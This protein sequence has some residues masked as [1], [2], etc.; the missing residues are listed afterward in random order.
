M[1]KKIF[2]PVSLGS[3]TAKN[4]LVRSGTSQ[5]MSTDLTYSNEKL[6]EIY[7][8]LADGGVGTNI[9]SFPLVDSRVYVTNERSAFEVYGKITDM[10]R[11]KNCISIAQLVLVNA[12]GND[13]NSVCDMFIRSAHTA[14]ECGYDGIQ[15]HAAHGLFLGAFL[16]VDRAKGTKL[17]TDIIRR[18]KTE[19]PDFH[20]SMKIN[21]DVEN[22]SVCQE[23]EN[24]G[25]DSVEVSG[26]NTSKTHI[27]PLVNE[28]YFK[29]FAEALSDKV[30]IPVILVG[31]N[32][33]IEN[34]E[35][36]LNESNIQFMALSRPLICE[37][38][39]PKRWETGDLAPAKC[40][41]CNMC[42]RTKWQEC[43][44]NT[45]L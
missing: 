44:Q 26:N 15:L 38:D 29:E 28:A 18:I 14:Y 31:G 24:A 39:L 3:L 16:S 8:A 41:S 2:E 36:L 17:L 11:R 12:H 25:L 45:I 40:V 20:I 19:I 33:S 1:E 21:E 5:G 10:C 27:Q 9:T 13:T 34:M 37:P 30:H 35:K 42:Y 32:R 7:S 6:I 43:I 23:C 22:I 4:R